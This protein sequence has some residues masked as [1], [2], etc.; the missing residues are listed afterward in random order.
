MLRFR[1]KKHTFLKIMLL[2][3]AA[4]ALGV[5]AGY[6]SIRYNV[7][8]FLSR[9]EQ[10]RPVPTEESAILPTYEPPEYISTMEQERE[11]AAT[12][13]PT[14]EAKTEQK[15]EYL[16]RED[17][18]E[19]TLFSVSPDGALLRLYTLPINLN[20]LKKEDRQQLVNGIRVENK[21]ELAM[22]IEDFGS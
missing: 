8:P 6:V 17:A 15:D 5:G 21:Q 20:A 13:T 7:F 22:L 9:G 3:I 18:G 12:P 2:L 4:C 14:E 19:A 10:P 1:K 16:V 11:P